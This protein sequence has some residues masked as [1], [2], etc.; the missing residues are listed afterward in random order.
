MT[1]NEAKKL[2]AGDKVTHNRKVY[3]VQSLILES[4]W[5]WCGDKYDNPPLVVTTD[6]AVIA[7]RLLTHS[8]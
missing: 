2:Q 7:H 1:K 5:W 3:S 8:S 6:G 4:D